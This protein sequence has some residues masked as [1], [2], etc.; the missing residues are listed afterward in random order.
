[1][2]ETNCRFF[3]C[4][5][6][7]TPGPT[8]KPPKPPTPPTPPPPHNTFIHTIYTCILTIC[9]A[10]GGGTVVSLCYKCKQRRQSNLHLAAT[11]RLLNE[12]EDTPILMSHLN[13]VETETENL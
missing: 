7:P 10:I 13:S 6:I 12:E 4:R 3:K 11:H 1:M 5:Q 8:P 2:H 9:G